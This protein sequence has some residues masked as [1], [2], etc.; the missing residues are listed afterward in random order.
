MPLI[1]VSEESKS[2]LKELSRK[3]GLSMSEIVRQWTEALGQIIEDKSDADRL[4]YM[5]SRH[6]GS[7]TKKPTNLVISR[8]A[9]LY[10]SSFKI[11][12]NE[13]V[14]ENESTV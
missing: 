11:G 7:E 3:S 10:I 14:N 12:I 13:E 5:S 9:G 8:I 6:I 4:T 2:V 1:R